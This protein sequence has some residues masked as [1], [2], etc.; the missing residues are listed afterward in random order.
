M[1]EGARR[2]AMMWRRSGHDE[3]EEGGPTMTRGRQARGQQDDG[4]R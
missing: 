3:K 4:M 1:R 2:G